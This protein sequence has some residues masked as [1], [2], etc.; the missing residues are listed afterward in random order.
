VIVELLALCTVEQLL[1]TLAAALARQP[2]ATVSVD[3]FGPAGNLADELRR[4]YRTRVRPY[5]TA[6]LARACATLQDRCHALTLAHR[7]QLELSDAITR[8]VSRP[9]GDAWLWKRRGAEASTAP[10]IAATLAVGTATAPPL[11]RPAIS[12]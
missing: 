9:Y 3:T 7:D 6:D 1:P 4:L 11:L 8:S 5:S 12:G 10:V 2:G